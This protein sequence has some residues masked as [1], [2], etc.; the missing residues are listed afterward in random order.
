MSEE[1]PL[2]F[3]VVRYGLPLVV[4]LFYL[5]SSLAFDY[6]PDSAYTTLIAARSLATSTPGVTHSDNTS[7]FSPNPLWVFFVGLGGTLGLD[8]LLTAKVFS[9][10]FTS[11]GILLV[12]LVAYELLRD[13][14]I[15]FCAALA[16]AMQSTLLQ[17]APSGTAHGIALALSLAAMFFLLR[18]EYLLATLLA[19]IST[20][21]FWEGVVLFL[22][23]VADVW[24]NSVNARRAAKVIASSACVY[25]AVLLPWGL[26]SIAVHGPV[27]PFLVPF[28][29]FV[30]G[31]LDWTKLIV[32]GVLAFV[33]VVLMVRKRGEGQGLLRNQAAAF[34]WM[35]CAFGICLVGNSDLWIVVVPLVIVFA[36]QGLQRIALSWNRP[37]VVYSAIVFLAGVLL[38]LSQMT[39]TQTTRGAM[40]EGMEQSLQLIPVAYWIKAQ[41]PPDATIQGVR[42]GILSYYAGREVGQY[43][44]FESGQIHAPEYIVTDALRVEG[45]ESVY[46]PGSAGGTYSY[47]VWRRR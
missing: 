17:A 44:M 22:V 29:D 34:I 47:A 18:N 26:Y 37:D 16:T 41:V 33:G 31:A 9:L 11:V 20:L 46:K 35:M 42:P 8:V 1:H 7:S 45:Y 12:Y 36:F 43:A 14:L 39:F 3:R 23:L 24:M 21:V 13:R 6:T 25:G 27:I 28:G 38:A 5:T 30:R 40:A 2:V 19:G 4:A 10:F 32:T 15:A